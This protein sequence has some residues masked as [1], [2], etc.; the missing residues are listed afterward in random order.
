M[1]WRFNRF[2]SNDLMT[3]DTESHVM[4][5]RDHDG[6]YKRHTLTGQQIAFLLHYG[7]KQKIFDGGALPKEATMAQ[8]REAVVKAFKA[9]AISP[10]SIPDIDVGSGGKR[11]TEDD[12]MKRSLL[13]AHSRIA[14]RKK[15]STDKQH[16]DWAAANMGTPLAEKLL[17]NAR[18][19]AEI[20]TN[21]VNLDEETE[22]N[23]TESGEQNSENADAA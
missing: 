5:I 23:G 14:N 11:L 15:F 19:L 6:D 21:D 13:L 18:E 4:S 16:V 8:R 20:D 7:M 22:Q 1:L 2:D 12:K 17:A 9:F 3:F 10:G